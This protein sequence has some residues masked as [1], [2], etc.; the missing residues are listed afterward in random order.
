MRIAIVTQLKTAYWKIAPA[1][2]KTPLTMTD[3]V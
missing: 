2:H 1:F 3:D